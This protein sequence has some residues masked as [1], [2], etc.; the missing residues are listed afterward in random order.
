MYCEW[1]KTKKNQPSGGETETE[2]DS[3]SK[4]DKSVRS[5]LII[6]ILFLAF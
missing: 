1:R 3:A 4:Q 6:E 5:E 2:A